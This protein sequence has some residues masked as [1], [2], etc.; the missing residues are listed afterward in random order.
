[1]IGAIEN[2]GWL[3]Q[4]YWVS[5][6]GRLYGRGLSSLQSCPKVLLKQ[7]LNEGAWELDVDTALQ[8]ILFQQLQKRTKR[9]IHYPSIEEYMRNK[10]AI[11]EEIADSLGVDSGVVKQQFTAIGFGMRRSTKKFLNKENGSLQNPTLT[12]NFGGSELLAENFKRIGF[13]KSYWEELYDLTNRL[14]K[15]VRKENP[16]W[17]R[18]K[19]E[20]FSGKKQIMTYLFFQGEAE[21]LRSICR[22]VGQQLI[23]PKHDAVVISKR[24]SSQEKS[25]IESGIYEDTG[26]R[27]GLSSKQL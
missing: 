5:P 2:D 18:S 16:Q 13:V 3:E 23:L 1:M 6:F 25:S 22:Q 27:V 19:E 11:R 26:F 21:I 20:G 17:M 24:I 15:A 8:S 4:N 9:E 12:E 14:T 10:K 7:F